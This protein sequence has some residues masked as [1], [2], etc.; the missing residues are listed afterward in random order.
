MFLMYCLRNSPISVVSFADVVVILVV[1]GW[2]VA[3]YLRVAFATKGVGA[4]VVSVY[5]VL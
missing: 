4:V 1:R 5:C 2:R 3:D